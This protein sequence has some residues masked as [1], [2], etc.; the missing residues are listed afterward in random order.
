MPKTVDFTGTVSHATM[1]EQDLLPKFLGVLAEYNPLAY[2]AIIDELTP[3]CHSNDN[4]DEILGNE[5]HTAW[6]SNTMAWI[7]NE[8]V[9]DAM[10]EIAPEGFYFGAH[11]GD[12][13]DYGFWAIEEDEL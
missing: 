10:N 13:C 3:F 12:G 5:D 1:R 7:I 2:N 9:W 11:P 8:S 4:I 6:H